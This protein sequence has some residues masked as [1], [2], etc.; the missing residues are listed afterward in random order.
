MRDEHNVRN[1]GEGPVA[2]FFDEYAPYRAFI[3]SGQYTHS[4]NEALRLLDGIKRMSLQQY[5][6][7]HKGTPFYVLGYAAFASH[8][9]SG[10][11]L[12]F[13][14]AVAADL[15]FHQGRL[16]T[17]ALQFIQLNADD[18]QP[19]LA[20]E[21]VKRITAS[22]EQLL[23]DYCSRQGAKGL[24]LAELRSRFFQKLLA[25]N[26]AHKR[27]LLTAL[28]SFVAEWPYRAKL[29]DLIDEGSREPFFLH[30]FRGC[31]LFESLLKEAAPTAN[32]QTLGPALQHHKQ[33]L[34]LRHIHTSSSEFNEI[35]RMLTS[36]MDIEPTINSCSQTRN[37]LGHN[38]VWMTG[39][40]T[41]QTYD[42]LIRNIS[43]SCLHAISTLYP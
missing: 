19:V 26:D 32:L 35:V 41:A 38:L 42:L 15:R 4:I 18:N 12:F 31:L 37:T 20:Q 39:N 43:A 11:S 1:R 33:A 14:A 5:Q 7:E 28:I 13:D 36:N 25:V 22:L 21:I 3:E 30:L 16:D 17:P 2:P 34:G 6:T 8:D 10:A 40:L 29:F 23:S 27:T 24:T 9:Y